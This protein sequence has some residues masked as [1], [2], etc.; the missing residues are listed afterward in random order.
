MIKE[1]N[2]IGINVPLSKNLFMEETVSYPT[3]VDALH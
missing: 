3:L 1:V 2:H